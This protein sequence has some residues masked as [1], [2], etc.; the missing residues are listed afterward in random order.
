MGMNPITDPLPSIFQ[1]LRTDLQ[2]YF[3]AHDEDV[4]YYRKVH[5]ESSR[6]DETKVNIWQERTRYKK[7]LSLICGHAAPLDQCDQKMFD[8]AIVY[9]D[10]SLGLI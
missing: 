6:G 8:L 3:T 2:Q 5:Q 7:D 10:R 4:E 9:L 1:H